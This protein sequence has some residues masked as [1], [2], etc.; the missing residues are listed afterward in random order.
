MLPSNFDPSFWDWLDCSRLLACRELVAAAVQQVQAGHAGVENGQVDLQTTQLRGEGI[1]QLLSLL[2][3]ASTQQQLDYAAAMLFPLHDGC[4]SDGISVEQLA[5]AA[6]ECAA[7]EQR[8]QQQPAAEA[9]RRLRQLAAALGSRSLDL[10]GAFSAAPG[11]RLPYSQLVRCIDVVEQAYSCS[12]CVSRYL[13]DAQQ[14][15]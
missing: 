14:L 10:A 1:P 8:M 4:D 3:P 7:V 15:C 9:G 13:L 6:E 5:A 2:L 11:Q 12:F